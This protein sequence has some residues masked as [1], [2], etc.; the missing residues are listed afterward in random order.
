MKTVYKYRLDMAFPHQ[1]ISMDE[2]AQ[3]LTVQIQD[4]IPHL[5]ALVDPTRPHVIRTVS[6]I[7]TGQPMP[8]DGVYISTF[9]MHGGALVFHAF[10]VIRQ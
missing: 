2:G 1:V 9:Q 3:M 7:G 4:G 10:E 6:I 8:D 5:W